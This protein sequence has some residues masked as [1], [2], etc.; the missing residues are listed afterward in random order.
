M[1]DGGGADG[2]LLCEVVGGGRRGGGGRI[3]GLVRTAEAIGGNQV[4]CHS[5][6]GTGGEHPRARTRQLMALQCRPL[7]VDARRKETPGLE[8]TSRNS[9]ARR[10]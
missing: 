3:S 5:G 10:Q 9:V 4:L 8:P 2:L 1:A 7:Q 6:A